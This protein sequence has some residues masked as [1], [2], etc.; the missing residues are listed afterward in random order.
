VEINRLTDFGTVVEHSTTAPEIKGL[1]A[2]TTQ[3]Q[4]FNFKKAKIGSTFDLE[5]LLDLCQ[6]SHKKLFYIPMTR[7][8][9]STANVCRQL[10]QWLQL[11]SKTLDFLF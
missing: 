11:S 10:D 7:P 1:D 5:P 6:V 8:S 3:H 2:S 4:N 9:Q